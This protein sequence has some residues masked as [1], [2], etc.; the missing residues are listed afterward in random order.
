MFLCPRKSRAASLAYH[1][2]IQFE[3][4]LY[5]ALARLRRTGEL[6][7]GGNHVS[8]TV[9]DL[10]LRLLVIGLVQIIERLRP[11]LQPDP[12]VKEQPVLEH[13]KIELL[14]AGATQRVASQI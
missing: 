11:E 3:P 1:S 8:R 4:E 10:D 5:L 9:E 13:R 12:F 7:C 2:P 14:Q 6:T